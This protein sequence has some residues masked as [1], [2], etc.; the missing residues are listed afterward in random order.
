MVRVTIMH[1]IGCNGT[2]VISET[3][4]PMYVIMGTFKAPQA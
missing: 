3:S 4:K 1:I 2:C